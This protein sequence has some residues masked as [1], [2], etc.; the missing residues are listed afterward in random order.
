MKLDKKVLYRHIVML[1]SFA[2]AYR[3]YRYANNPS[4]R[5][6]ECRKLRKNCSYSGEKSTTFFISGQVLPEIDASFGIFVCDFLMLS[7]N[8]IKNYISQCKS[9]GIDIVE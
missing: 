1:Q 2:N 3:A 4:L 5:L 6:W 9:Y 7:E 8:D